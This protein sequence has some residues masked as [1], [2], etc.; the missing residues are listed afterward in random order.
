MD[1]EVNKIEKYFLEN[2]KFSENLNN[3]NNKDLNEIVR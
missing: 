2:K 1:Y 3:L